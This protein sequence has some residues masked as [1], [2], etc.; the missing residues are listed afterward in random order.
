MERADIFNTIS[1]GTRKARDNLRG[2]L[3]L[4]DWFVGARFPRLPIY[5]QAPGLSR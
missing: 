1:I 2:T 5:E 3:R 4:R